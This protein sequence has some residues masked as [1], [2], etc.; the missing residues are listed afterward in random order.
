MRGVPVDRWNAGGQQRSSNGKW[1][2]VAKWR[3]RGRMKGGQW[4]C[5]DAGAIGS[6]DGRSA[7]LSA[8]NGYYGTQCVNFKQCWPFWVCVSQCNKQTR[9]IILYC[10]LFMRLPTAALAPLLSTCYPFT[11][12]VA[13]N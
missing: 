7:M 8:F 12:R 9:G 3:Y 11:V 1:K 6:G 13:V 4:T 5:G 2:E 10:F